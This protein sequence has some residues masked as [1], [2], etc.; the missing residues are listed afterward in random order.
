LPK[1]A[2]DKILKR[3]LKEEELKKLQTSAAKA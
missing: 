2:V 1:S 3:E